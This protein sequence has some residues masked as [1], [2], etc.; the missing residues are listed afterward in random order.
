MKIVE[1]ERFPI[2]LNPVKTGYRADDRLSSIARVDTV[3]IRVKTDSA[4]VG[5]G[6]AASIASYLNQ[7][8]GGLLDWLEVYAT[9]LVGADALN[10]NELN[11]RLDAVSGEFPPGCQPARAAIDMA[12]YDI[13]GKAREVPVFD[14]LGGAY[15]TELEMLTN[16]YEDTPEEMAAEAQRFVDRGF[17]GLKVKIGTS[18]ILDGRNAENLERERR[19]LDAVLKTVDAGIYIDADA[20]QSWA[21]AGLARNIITSILH[22]EFYGNLSLEQ[23]LHH[24]DLKGHAE[25][26]EKLA[27]PIILDESVTSPEA[28]MQIARASAADRIVLKIGRVGG[29]TKARAIADICEAAAIGVSVDTLPFTKLGDAALCHPAATLRDPFPIDAE[30]HLWFDKT[31][32]VGGFE[33]S[34]G[35]VILGDQPG[36]G[37]ELDEQALGALMVDA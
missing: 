17:S 16:L 24:L 8:M 25:L 26:R 20:N 18:I 15:R 4:I 2:R 21:N 33:I 23:P 9:A 35:R 14:V 11:R 30:G 5:L 37:V 13:I 3:V 22:E 29:L 19:K 32:F 6:E 7:T 10:L 34:N 1:I 28:M 12:I 36:L 27:I 31:P